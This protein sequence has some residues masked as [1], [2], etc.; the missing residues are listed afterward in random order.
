MDPPGP[1][2]LL[3]NAFAEKVGDAVMRTTL[4]ALQT[5]FLRG[6]GEDYRKW[7]TD[8]EYR[9]AREKAAKEA[10]AEMNRA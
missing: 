4:K 2:A 9:A 10:A 6:L 7:A 3:P 5:V 1:F 8:A